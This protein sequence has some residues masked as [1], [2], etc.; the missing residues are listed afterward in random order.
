[1]ARQL[2]LP[3]RVNQSRKDPTQLSL[4]LGHDLTRLL[5]RFQIR[6]PAFCCHIFMVSCWVWHWS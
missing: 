5:E 6:H 2:L 3:K 1:M 4:V